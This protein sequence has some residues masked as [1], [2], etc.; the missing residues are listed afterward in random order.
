MISRTWLLERNLLCAGMSRKLLAA[1]LAGCAGIWLWA[2]LPLGAK[3]IYAYSV[4]DFL[5][6]ELRDQRVRVSGELVPG[7]LCRA[8]ADCGYRFAI[9]DHAGRSA[10]AA[11][12]ELPLSLWVSYESCALPDTFRDVPG[13]AISLTVEGERCQTCHDFQAT[14]VFAKCSGKYEKLGDA[15]ARPAARPPPL[16]QALEPTAL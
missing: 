6:R 1:S 7:S 11:Q 3:P 10:A 14:R 5:A 16:C 13:Y 2:L 4:Q 12:Q 9:A 15:G 8:R